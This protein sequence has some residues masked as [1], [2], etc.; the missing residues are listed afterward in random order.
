[1]RVVSLIKYVVCDVCGVMVCA[2]M[3]AYV[4]VCLIVCACMC[5][6]RVIVCVPVIVYVSVFD[7]CGVCVPV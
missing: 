1:M 5:G 2:C 3:C 6:M 7:V 4:R